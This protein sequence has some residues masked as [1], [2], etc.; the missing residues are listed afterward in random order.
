MIS[1]PPSQRIDGADTKSVEDTRETSQDT[2]NNKI[3]NLYATDL[4]A[5]LRGTNDVASGGDRVQTPACLDE[6][7]LENERHADRPQDLR[8]RVATKDF[9]NTGPAFGR[10]GKPPEMI[11]VR[12]LIKNSVPRVVMKDGIRSTTVKTP[13]TMPTMAAAI[14]PNPDRQEQTERPP[15][16]RNT[17]RTAPARKLGPRT[18]RPRPQIRTIT[19]PAAMIAV[20][21]V[22]S[23]RFPMLLGVRNAGAV[24]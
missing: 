14:E 16:A 4:D 5:Y 12:P 9:L 19:K 7:E 24:L 23:A 21:A 22:Y 15:V 8:Y 18:D 17:S 6:H 20:I 2:A 3:P 1:V 10:T 11:R 13:L